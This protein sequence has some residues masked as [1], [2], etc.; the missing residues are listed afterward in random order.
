YH[1]YAP[2]LTDKLK[3]NSIIPFTCQI[4]YQKNILFMAPKEQIFVQAQCTGSSCSLACW[5]T[6]RDLPPSQNSRDE[7][8]EAL[9]VEVQP[10]FFFFFKLCGSSLSSVVMYKKK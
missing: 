3:I 9:K 8:V 4:I 2:T 5:D 7:A 1:G 10:F 6:S